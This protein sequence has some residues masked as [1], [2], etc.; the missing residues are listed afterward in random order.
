MASHLLSEFNLVLGLEWSLYES[1]EA[2]RVALPRRGVPYYA[3]QV[4]SGEC[5]QGVPADLPLQAIKRA[6]SPPLAGALVLANIM[7][8]AVIFQDMGDDLVWVC[9]VNQGVPIPGFDR[10]QGKDQALLTLAEVLSF[11]PHLRQVGTHAQA[12]S[13]LSDV[14]LGLDR[15]KRR[16]SRILI[17]G[18]SRERAFRIILL[19]GL[20]VSVYMAADWLWPKIAPPPVPP[21]VNA[22]VS[23]PPPV[24]DAA[25]LAA[26]EQFRRELEQARRELLDA[27]SPSGQFLLWYAFWR[28]IPLSVMG[29]RPTKA[30]CAPLYCDVKWQ[31]PH[32]AL[33]SD[34]SRLPGVLQAVESDGVLMR[35]ALAPLLKRQ[36]TNA[37][38][39]S[40][41]HLQDVRAGMNPQIMTLQINR[42]QESI[43][44][45]PAKTAEKDKAVTIGARGM[46]ILSSKNP[47]FLQA[48]L[49]QMQQPGVELS[50]ANIDLDATSR[51]GV[52]QLKG[53]YVERSEQ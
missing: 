14:L 4:I 51:R 6:K 8:N 30:Q 31:R 27:A 39:A 15:A 26:Q 42:A 35:T 36:Y 25:K 24:V 7:G 21:V 43:T 28:D 29:F 40:G 34:S 37:S 23:A 45:P 44:Y 41:T 16:N 47:I 11:M 18:Q 38:G 3:R 50:E 19:A 46:W 48:A 13:T 49:E 52:I 33:P 53:T 10:V 20:M 22:P 17:P 5:A 12:T 2:A 9:A 32:G 1:I